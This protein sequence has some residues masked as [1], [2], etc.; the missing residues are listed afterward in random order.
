MKYLALI[1]CLSVTA[2]ASAVERLDQLTLEQ[3]T[4]LALQNHRAL[5]VSQASLDMAVAQYQQAMAAFRPHVN[6]E[7]GFQRADQDRTFTFAGAIQTPAMDISSALGGVL[8]PV[9]AGLPPAT[10]QQFGMAFAQG[11]ATIPGQTIPMNVEVKMFDRDVTKAAVNL[12]YPIYTGGKKEAVTAMAQKGV[13]LARQDSR[14]TE[15][16]VVRDVTKYYHGAQFAQQMA[17]LASDTLARFQVLDELTGQL[18]QNASLK[19]KKTDFLRSKTTTALVRSTVQEA[20]YGSTL[21]RDALANAM[22]LPPNSQLSLAPALAAPGFD[23]QLESLISDAMTFNPDKQR[24]ELA[25]EVMQHKI[26][27][28]KSAYLPMVGLDASIYQVWNG[29]KSG[30]FNDANR[31]GWTIGVG[32]KWSLFDGGLTRANVNEALAGKAKLEAQRGLLDEGLALQI[33]DDVMRIQRSLT[34]VDDSAKAQGFAEE[35]RKLNVRAYQEEMVET[36]DVIEAQLLES[37]A[38]ASLYRAHH[39]LRDALT[40]LDF[41]VGKAAQKARP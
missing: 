32:L 5:R 40:D 38:T 11:G 21:T 17:Q 9:I 7:A 28:A 31:T 12:S 14:K 30:L 34:Q 16:E 41:Q 22:G 3:A 15:L 36:K 23:G 29:Y 1:C 20:N 18:Y 8:G 26:A 27:D 37:F 2:S 35:N 24:L 33:K 19:V 25:I 13:E 4:K 10:Q 39:D 6:L